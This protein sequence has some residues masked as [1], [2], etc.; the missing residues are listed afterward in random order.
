MDRNDW[1]SVKD[2]LP[3]VNVDVI[4]F[5]KHRQRFMSHFVG[6]NTEWLSNK[7]CAVWVDDRG[8]YSDITHWMPLPEPP[9]AI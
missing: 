9:D 3:E 5:N 1:I 4:V 7:P 2:R 6:M 8:A